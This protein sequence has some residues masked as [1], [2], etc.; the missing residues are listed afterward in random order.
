MTQISTMDKAAAKTISA[1]V[2]KALQAV[3]K[4]HGLT[5]QMKGGSYDPHSGTYQPKMEFTLP[6]IANAAV[7]KDLKLFGIEGKHGTVFTI[8]GREY[9]IDGVN[10]RA[11]RMPILAHSTSDG[12]TYKFEAFSVARALGQEERLGRVYTS[13]SGATVEEMV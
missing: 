10:F 12:R 9:A 6:A 4:E 5:L 11:K 7:A 2:E 1:A 13:P 3:A 8:N